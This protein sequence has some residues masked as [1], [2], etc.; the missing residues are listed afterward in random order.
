MHEWLTLSAED[1]EQHFPQLSAA[2]TGAPDPPPDIVTTQIMD[3]DA[4]EPTATTLKRPRSP[5]SLGDELSKR[6]KTATT[7]KDLI[8]IPSPSTPPEETTTRKRSQSPQSPR[9]SQQEPFK[10]PKTTTTCEDLISIQSPRTPPEQTETSKHPSIKL[11]LPRVTADRVVEMGP[12][13]ISRS[14][15][16]SQKLKAEMRAGTHKINKFQQKNFEDECRISDPHVKFRYGENWRV[17]HSR[18]GK[19]LVMTEAY[20]STRFRQHLKG[21]KKMGS[22]SK[23]TTLNSFLVKAPAQQME[24]KKAAKAPVLANYPCLGITASHDERVPK[25]ITRTG[26]D[27]GGARSITKI[28]EELFN[29]AYGELSERKKSQVDTA[30]MHEWSFHFDRLRMAIHSSK[31][32]KL[33][34]APKLNDGTHTCRECLDMHN[35]DQR[36]KSGLQKPM[37]NP[38][39]FKYLNEQYQGKSTAERYAKTQGLLEIIL[40]KVRCQVHSTKFTVT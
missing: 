6:P 26:A 23:F 35:S 25:F 12:V 10:R 32:K 7:C 37:P 15:I 38:E 22:G 33:V 16:A 28:A 13:G 17:F 29:K 30:Q 3:V 9:S 18:C 14:A 8:S 2:L 20:N 31:C 39:N 4:I 21:C 36:L 40:D 11:V 24:A 34:A 19:W 5:N 1:D 27:G